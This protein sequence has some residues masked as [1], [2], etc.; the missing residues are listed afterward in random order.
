MSTRHYSQLYRRLRDLDPHDYQRVIRTYEERETEIG[1][2]DV[3]EHFELTV[4]YVDALYC[5][6]AFRQHQLMVDLAIETGIRHNIVEVEGIS[7]D[8]FQH[9]LFHKAAAAFRLNQLDVAIHVAREL[10]RIDAGRE[11]YVR[12]LRA[13]YFKEQTAT[14]QFGRAGFI[15]CVLLAAFLITLNLLVVTNFYPMHVGNVQ[16]TIALVFL[17]GVICLS[18]AYGFAYWR[19]HR[20][21]YAFQ[22]GQSNK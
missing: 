1:R 11:L 22:Q 18:G 21:A 13:A 7:G 2:L 5:T 17:A 19:A 3:L 14:L 4:Y 9:L 6:G 8:I 12:F 20:A 10:I 16:T 15:L